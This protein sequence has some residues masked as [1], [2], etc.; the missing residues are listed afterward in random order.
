MSRLVIL[1]LAFILAACGGPPRTS[2][3][4]SGPDRPMRIVSL[5]Y[6]ADQYVLKLAD[7]EQV[8]ALSPDATRDFSY[9]RDHAQ[10]L[11][12]VRPV[13]EDVLILKPDLVVR[14]YG[15][16]P[17]ATAFFERA[18]I[19]VLNVGWA[20]N[21]DSEEV[22]SIPNII[23]HMADG[24][25]HPGRGRKLV[26]EFRTRLTELQARTDGKSAL[27]MT[28]AGVTSGP[29]SM[30]HE[31]LLAAGLENFQTEP[32]WRSIPLEA[33]AYDQPD[34][35]AAAFFGT[36]TNHPD[37][38]TPMKHPVASNLLEDK[39]VVQLEGSWTACGG[40]FILDAIEALVGGANSEDSRP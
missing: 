37:A 1:L 16:G 15:G 39:T 6:C 23:R 18:G 40:W 10:G 31:M 34:L 33:L 28:P 38:W 14:A 12:T 29:G 22:G 32:G 21:V 30:V 25:G 7:R 5:D 2:Q 26:A 36:L 9:M 17:N 19:P 35:I 27:Y 20:S 24:L 4:V 11:P 3:D 13:A 8:L